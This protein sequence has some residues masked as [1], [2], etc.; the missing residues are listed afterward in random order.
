MID[1]P[2]VSNA[3]FPV[4]RASNFFK[5]NASSNIW[6]LNWMKKFFHDSTKQVLLF[7]VVVVSL[8][9]NSRQPV[10][11]FGLIILSKGKLLKDLWKPS[12]NAAETRSLIMRLVTTNPGCHVPFIILS[13]MFSSILWPYS[14]F[15]IWSFRSPIFCT[16]TLT[17]IVSPGLL[18]MVVVWTRSSKKK[19]DDIII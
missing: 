3:R 15:E 8:N 6:W 1:T 4:N 9:Q 2:T 11:G 18:V 19:D 13:S 12:V 17:R 10:T 7:T 5:K 16:S 14:K